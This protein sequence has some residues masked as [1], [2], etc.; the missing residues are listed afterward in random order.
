L[1]YVCCWLVFPR[2]HRGVAHLDSCN[3]FFPSRGTAKTPSY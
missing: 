3:T 1:H 2:R